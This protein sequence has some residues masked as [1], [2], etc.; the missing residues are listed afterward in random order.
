MQNFPQTSIDSEEAIHL[1]DY[2]NVLIRRRQAFLFTFLSIFL[3]VAAYTFFMAPVYEATAT[4]RV[5][6]EQGK[7]STIEE[8]TFGTT[9]PV[10]AE[11]EILKSRTNAE[12]V[13]RRLNL[14]LNIVKEKGDPSFKILELSSGSNTEAYTM[15]LTDGGD[16]Y[17]VRD[18]SGVIVGSGRSGVL[19]QGKDLKLLIDKLQGSPGN[20]VRIE[21]KAF[22]KVVKELRSVT[23]AI[24]NPKQTNIIKL[25]YLNTNPEIAKNVANSLVQAYLE[26]NIAFKAEEASRTVDFLDQQLDNIKSDLDVAERNL[27]SFKRTTGIIMLNAESEELIKKYSETEKRRMDAMLQKKQLAFALTSL[28]DAMSHQQTY[29]P[30]VFRDDPLI[31]GMAEKA[32]ELEVQKQSLLAEYTTSHPTVRMIQEQIDQIQRNIQ[33]TY[34]TGLSNTDRMENSITAQLADYEKKLKRLPAKERELARLTRIFK[35]NADIY[36]FLLQKREEARIAK[37]STIS[38]IDI[39]DPAIT[40]DEPVK[41]RKL[42]YLF[43]GFLSGSLAGVF[44]VFFVDYIDDTI[45]DADTAKRQLQVPLLT[46][47]PFISTKEEGSEKEKH[48]SLV[49]HYE[50]KSTITEA[51]RSLRTSIHFSGVSKKRQVL[52]ITSCLPYEGKTTI[53]GN[54]A[55]IMSQTGGKALLLDCDLRRPS[56]HKLFGYNKAPGLTEILAGENNIGNNVHNTGIL[57]LDFISAGTTPPNPAEL[58]GSEKMKTL[59]QEFRS[60]YDTVLLDAPPVLAVTDALLLST[61]TDMVFMIIELGRVPIKAAIHG[62]ELLQNVGAPLA[63]FVLNDKSERRLER[64]GYYGEKYYRY[65]YYGYAYSNYDDDTPVK[66]KK[67][68]ISWWNKTKKK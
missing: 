38:N 30:S 9:A 51:F 49:T 68:K 50:P 43:I 35:V 60:R 61:I 29:S 8:I 59:I 41:P 10:N 66:P 56:L 55:V 65:G 27:E 34:E 16:T 2:I 14:H 33:V 25:S 3:G 24:E 1:Q 62:K 11:I 12:K 47:I 54:L 26:Q 48:V 5:K 39:V 22:N 13:V 42:L 37:A 18:D 52:M 7:L 17:T 63:G 57:G 53:M 44:I 67:R 31:A 19:L 46:V 21:I 15:E 20:K 45:K 40:P 23:T 4:L 64:Y 6:E 58:L 36:T 32:A 28:N